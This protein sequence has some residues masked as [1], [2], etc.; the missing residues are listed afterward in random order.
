[1]GTS[2][3]CFVRVE[4]G[5]VAVGAQAV[6]A[7]APGYDRAALPEE[8]PVR[9]VQLGPLWMTRTEIP[10]SELDRCRVEGRCAGAATGAGDRPATGVDRAEAA[11]LCAFLGGRLPTGDEWEAAARGGR[12][13]RFPWGVVP[14]CPEMWMQPTLEERPD[15]ARVLEACGGM[16]ASLSAGLSKRALDT[17]GDELAGLPT[18]DVVT[19]CHELPA[20]D[21]AAQAE[22]LRAR[23]EAFARDAA[24]NPKCDQTGVY[25]TGE[26]RSLDPW[27]LAAMG[28]N[29]A[30]WVSD[31]VGGK[32]VLRG[33]SWASEPAAWRSSARV[34]VDPGLRA[35]DVGL[36]CVWVGGE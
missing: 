33:G 34:V 16:M 17:L 18:D 36:R 3:P 8:G 26:A 28:G 7:G 6:D 11:A 14:R 32:G 13:Q 4:G 2:N 30:E 23:V 24:V 27:G 21:A 5:E 12:G 31:D 15:S 29:V 25:P 20:A 9:T 35:D 10:A 1:V 19:A 22:W